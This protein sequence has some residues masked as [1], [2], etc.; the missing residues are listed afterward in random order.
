[1]KRTGFQLSSLVLGLILALGIV[2]NVDAGGKQ[3][4]PASSGGTL[5][6]SKPLLIYTNSGTEGK[7][8]WITAKAKEA[9]FNINIVNIG[10]GDLLS[11]AIAEKNNQLADMV[12][13]LNAM[14]YEVL[15]TNNLLL[16]F[17]PP[18]WVG[19][20]DMSVGDKEG[21]YYPIVI[22][23]LIMAYRTDVYTPQTAPKD[24]VEAATR[25][26]FKGKINV[27]ALGGGTSQSLIA[28]ILVRYRDDKGELGISRE[29][30]DVI[31]QYIQDHH[32]CTADEDWFGNFVSGKTPMTG[33]WGNGYFQRRDQNKLTAIDYV[34]PEIGAP[35]VVEQVAIFKGSKNVELAKAF[36]EWFGSPQIQGEFSKQF[37]AA[38][39]S[40][41][42]L[43]QSSQEIR[44][45]LSSLK[46]QP[47]DWKFV[48]DHIEAWME[49]INLEYVK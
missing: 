24:W 3:D 21:Y 8:D 10:G 37:D 47:I 23:P 32:L 34:R 22:Q 29:G 25:P 17:D 44:E 43:A 13:G 35:F 45:M 49:K 26:Q 7:G 27:L 9:G 16:K 1:M 48:G 11:R 39:A 33:I 40:K 20:V 31:R 15:K 4:S 41:T 12:F 2:W 19:D 38:P 46:P 14:S 30:W 28:G 6:K 42:A 5:D 18:S 36:I